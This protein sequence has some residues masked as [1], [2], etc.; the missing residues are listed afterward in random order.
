VGLSE[1][2]QRAPTVTVTNHEG[3]PLD[4][5][6]LA[7]IGSRRVFEQKLEVGSGATGRLT[8]SHVSA[9]AIRGRLLLTVD[10]PGQSSPYRQVWLQA[11]NGQWR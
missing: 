1:H 7:S 10:R 3:Q 8:L 9:P 5:T 2:G 6:V 4:Y 11:V